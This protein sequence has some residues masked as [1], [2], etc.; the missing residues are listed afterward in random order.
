MT[1]QQKGRPLIS[2]L[3]IP[4][5][6]SII[7]IGAAGTI[8]SVLNAISSVETLANAHAESLCER[9]NDNLQVF[10]QR[11]QKAIKSDQELIF[12]GILNYKDQQTIQKYL[13]HQVL[14]YPT[15][16]SIYFGSS[17]GGFAGSGR[18][19]DQGIY[20]NTGTRNFLPGTFYKTRINQMGEPVELLS[21]FSGFDARTR[22][23]YTGAVKSGQTY[24]TAPYP[25]FTGQDL[26]IAVSLPVY[27]PETD[28]LL[29]VISTDLFFSQID[30]FLEQIG[31]NIH[32]HL[33]LLDENNLLLAT[34]GK[35]IP[36]K[37]QGESFLQLPGSMSSNEVIR[38]ASVLLE[39]KKEELKNSGVSNGDLFAFRERY[40]M[41]VHVLETP[42]GEKWSLLLT[43]PANQFLGRLYFISQLTI[44]LIGL[45]IFIEIL[46]SI[47]LAR[48]LTAP[49]HALIASMNNFPDDAGIDRQDILQIQEFEA[50]KAAY[51]RGTR[52]VRELL[53]KLQN[54]VT[55]R[56]SAENELRKEHKLL[57]Q[58]LDEKEVLLKEVYHRTKNNLNFVISLVRLHMLNGKDKMN[59][60]DMEALIGKIQSIM[61]VNRKLYQA[62]DLENLD[63]G[64][65]LGE[66]AELQVESVREKYQ[67]IEISTEAQPISIDMDR[68]VSCG[69][70]VSELV[71]N[72]LK[73][74]FPQAIGGIIKL[75]VRLADRNEIEISLHNDGIQLPKG[76]DIRSQKGLG[77]T[78]VIEIV[79]S[80][81]RG[82]ISLKN[83]TGVEFVI[84]FPR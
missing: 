28:E 79:E 2:Y 68:A 70:I 27:S 80:Q 39:E 45:V 29:G 78:L 14:E 8:F 32:A 67:K 38:K 49:L 42:G 61:L 34:S 6:S 33:A 40:F 17:N 37:K 16:S 53:E 21:E 64:A 54:E 84:R 9:V 71:S 4:L 48:R 81:L 62:G 35:E 26:A 76:F 52:R 23:W 10:L 44:A 59:Y 69:L 41:H 31:Q 58:S 46:L 24:W 18:E 25:L 1:G 3:F 15:I 75:K 57:T 56:T 22:P 66:V 72:A 83:S 36:L 50:V 7:I 20:Y 65:Y 77:L 30:G 55:Q 43:V 13:Y 47:A 74:A 73:Y 51:N 12:S 19:G 82:F 60:T 63:L 5:L 11:P